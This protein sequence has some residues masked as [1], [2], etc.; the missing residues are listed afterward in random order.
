MTITLLYSG[1]IH[2]TCYF[3][4]EASLGS[5]YLPIFRIEKLPVA[6]IMP[7][8]EAVIRGMQRYGTIEPCPSRCVLES[9]PSH[10]ADSSQLLKG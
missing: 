10:D 7:L 9:E 8:D 1:D 6:Q 3:P 2:K 4:Y 5:F